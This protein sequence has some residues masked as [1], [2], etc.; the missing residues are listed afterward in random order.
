MLDMKYR[1]KAREIS[2]IRLTWGQRWVFRVC[3]YHQSGHATSSALRNHVVFG[4]K[5]CFLV[6]QTGEFI[7]ATKIQECFGRKFQS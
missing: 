7:K 6:L 5:Q 3:I 2:R 1:S 4:G